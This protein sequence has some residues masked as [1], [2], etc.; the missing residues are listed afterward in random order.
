VERE[1]LPLAAELGLGVVVMQPL[2]EGRLARRATHRGA[3]AQLATLG[4]GSQAEAVLRWIL[5]D[6]RVSAAIPATRSPAHMAA[7]AAAGSGPWLDPDQRELVGRLV[8]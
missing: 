8:A 4:I 5:S 1:I 7:N 2:A 3:H 6:P